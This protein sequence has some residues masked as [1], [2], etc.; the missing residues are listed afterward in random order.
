[1]V[2]SDTTA[3]QGLIQECEFW[4]NLGDGTISGDTTLLKQFTSRLNRAYDAVLPLVLSIGDKMRWDDTNHADHPI[5]TLDLSSSYNDYEALV[6]DNGLSILN[7]T[8]VMILESATSTDYRPLRRLTLD[9]P[10]ALRAMSPNPSD[11]G[12][13][14]HFIEK[15]NVVFLWPKPNYS[16]T[17]GIK[18]FFERIPDYFT[19]SDTTQT[20][21]IPSPFH[22]LLALYASLDWILVNKPDQASL[23]TRIEARITQ[24][25][26]DLKSAIENRNPVRR[27]AYAQQTNSI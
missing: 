22:P 21:G 8:D 13:P 23:I 5:G 27:R 19:S 15:D 24:M 26:S 12:V 9:D 1:M 11:V 17:A 16:A 18:L 6:D 7:I 14:S 20:P 4:T 2:F 10:R 3:K 25:R